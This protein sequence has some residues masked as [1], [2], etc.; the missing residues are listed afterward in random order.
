MSMLIKSIRSYTKLSQQEL[1]DKLGV[2]S[3]VINQWEE[4]SSVPDKL[5]Q[6]KLY[7]FCQEVNIPIY[8]MM[9]QRMSKRLIAG[10]LCSA[11]FR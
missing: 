1:A 7:A 2:T 4:A 5:A 9:M 10:T 11:M 3:A 6:T 8:D